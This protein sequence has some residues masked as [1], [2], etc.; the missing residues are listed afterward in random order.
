MNVNR[1]ASL[2]LTESDEETTQEGAQIEAPSSASEAS[3]VP[4]P[5]VTSDLHVIPAGPEPAAVLEDG[6][7]VYRVE[8]TTEALREEAPIELTG[9]VWEAVVIREGPSVN[10]RYYT[11]ECL[12]ASIPLWEGDDVCDY[13]WLPT[14]QAVRDAGHIPISVE[15]GFPEGTF[16]NKIGHLRNVRAREGRDGRLELVA[17]VCVTDE[18]FRQKLLNN[19]KSGGRPPGLSIHAYGQGAVEMREGH[20]VQVIHRL[21]GTRE[22][23]VVSKPAAGGAFERLVAAQDTTEK[24]TPTM[25]WA[26][27]RAFLAGIFP[28]ASH[29]VVESME[30]QMLLE[31]VAQAL[32][33]MDASLKAFVEV[34]LEFLQAGKTDEAGRMLEK[35]LEQM[36]GAPAAEPMEETPVDAV[37]NVYESHALSN[38]QAILAEAQRINDDTR[39]V[40]EV[41]RCSDILD[42]RLKE[43]ALPEV[44]AD[45][46][47]SQFSGQTFTEA[48]LEAEIKYAKDILAV[49]AGGMALIEGQHRNSNGARPS[50]Q[51][52]CE[53]IDKIRYGADLLFGYPYQQDESLTESDRE[54]YATLAKSPRDYTAAALY[55]YSTGDWGHTNFIQQGSP[56]K[57]A[58]TTSSF[59]NILGTSM[60]RTLH[61][62]MRGEMAPSWEPFIKQVDHLNLKQHDRIVAGGFTTLPSVGQT[63]TYQDLGVPLELPMNYTLGKTGGI[64]VFSEETIFNDDLG[65]FQTLIPALR[66]A[67]IDTRDRLAWNLLIGNGGG[68]GTNTDTSY[69]GLEHYHAAHDNL[70]NAALTHAALT[71]AVQSVMRTRKIA[72]RTTIS[73]DH[74]NSVGTLTVASTSGFQAGNYARINGEIVRITAI[75]SST[76]ATIV[77]SQLGSAAAAHTSGDAVVVFGASMGLKALNMHLVVPIGLYET[78]RVL[79]ESDRTAG[80]EYNNKNIWA[81]QITVVPVDEQ[82]LGGDMNNWFLTTTWQNVPGLELGYFNGARVPDIIVQDQPAVGTVFTNDQ[83]TYKVKFRIGGKGIMHEGRYGAIVA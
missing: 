80:N 17:E 83:L 22:L 58:A 76:T 4:G 25:N 36:G 26:Q 10:G 31:S 81:G 45:K 68:G 64:F 79:A 24:E 77:R 14:N 56:L 66:D 1:Y 63:G 6:T 16:R 50:I 41:N 40:V 5:T 2:R 75:N 71:T 53:S 27:L 18:S 30:E 73:Q 82:Y 29:R 78:A 74:T 35:A 62:V 42:K 65:Y 13:G 61:F 32:L 44:V 72:F 34:A 21:T 33:E 43:A 48:A 8:Y 12:Q 55:H 46:I 60:N 70:G 59:A 38:A 15:R 51:I 67:A 20:Q 3:T 54:I 23:T 19:H 28:P 11:R 39:N 7:P 69:D 52:L 57:E 49:N 37:P 47:R 9:R